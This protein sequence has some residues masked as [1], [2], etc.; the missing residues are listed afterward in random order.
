M[1]VVM[2]PVSS[3]SA[4]GHKTG[5]VMYSGVVVSLAIFSRVGAWCIRSVSSVYGCSLLR[6]ARHTRY[7]EDETVHQ[8]GT[9]E[10]LGGS[11]SAEE[12]MGIVLT[13]KGQVRTLKRKLSVS[14][15]RLATT[16]RTR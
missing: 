2:Q 14:W 12:H 6:K 10:H 11:P 3:L 8:G 1:Y 13:I 4:S 7:Q 16:S 15:R 5:I 9:L